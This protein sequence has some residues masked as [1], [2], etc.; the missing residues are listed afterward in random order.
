[1]PIRRRIASSAIVAL[2]HPGDIPAV[3]KQ[4]ASDGTGLI[5]LCG[6]ISPA[7]RHKVA[8]AVGEKAR[9][10]SV[11]FGIE[12]LPAAAAYNA[13]YLAGKSQREA[14]IFMEAGADPVRDRFARIGQG[15]HT[16]FVAVPDDETGAQVAAEL[17]DVGVALIELYGGFSTRGIAL[18]IEAVE[19]RAPVGA[20]SFALD[21]LD[22]QSLQAV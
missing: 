21:Q 20:G 7:V 18:V 9:V 17:C 8:V 16:T 3:A 5:E 6:G 2:S 4:L 10:S 13:A 19:R 14:F 11:T 22:L 15:Q 12:S 1:M